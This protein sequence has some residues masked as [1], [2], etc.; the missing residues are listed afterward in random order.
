MLMTIQ[1]E[2][3]RLGRG[4]EAGGGG[5]VR[6]KNSAKNFSGTR[7]LRFLESYPTPLNLESARRIIFKVSIDI[8]VNV[9]GICV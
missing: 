3:L 1:H 8:L 5:G 7:N 9:G 2:D 6:K 4:A